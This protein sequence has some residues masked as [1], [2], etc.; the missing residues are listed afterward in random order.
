MGIAIEVVVQ[1]RRNW[2][3]LLS[4]LSFDKVGPAL[5]LRMYGTQTVPIEDRRNQFVWPGKVD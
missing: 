3:N 1:L 2:Q 5:S 4:S